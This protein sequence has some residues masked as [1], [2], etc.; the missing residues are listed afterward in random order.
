MKMTVTVE[1]PFDTAPVKHGRINYLEQ[2]F[3]LH[4]DEQGLRI[5]VTDYHATALRL[6]WGDIF[7]LAKV[8]G[9]PP[10]GSGREP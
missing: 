5:E 6:S 8:A 3:V 4:W 2:G 1:G 7:A 9:G 10:A